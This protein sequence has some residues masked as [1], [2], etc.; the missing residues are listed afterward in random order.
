MKNIIILTGLL[1]FSSYS[2][3]HGNQAHSTLGDK[4]NINNCNPTLKCPSAKI[5]YK[6]KIVT[7]T[8]IKEIK[9]KTFKNSVSLFL[10]ASKTDLQDH[11]SGNVTVIETETELELGLMY[12]RYLTE[13]YKFSLLGTMNKTILLGI[14]KNF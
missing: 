6:N 3:G 7:K 10:G 9:A 12:Q 1:M 4:N 14:G 13:K 8:V 2:Y 11:K 5:I